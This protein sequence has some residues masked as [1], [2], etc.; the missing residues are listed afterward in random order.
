M[1]MRFLKQVKRIGRGR[2]FLLVF[3]VPAVLW[4]LVFRYFPIAYLADMSLHTGSVG[5]SKYVGLDNYRAALSDPIFRTAVLHTIEY[6]VVLV[7]LQ[8]SLA[9]LIA[10]GINSLRR[11]WARDTALT[12]YFLPL[13][14]STAAMSLVFV[15]LYDP[16]FGV[17]NYG[18]TAIGLPAQGYLHSPP[19]ALY[20]VVAMSLWKGL[21]FP[22]II[23]LAALLAI[24]RELI[25]ATAVDGASAWHRFWKLTLPLLRPTTTLLVVI[26]GVESLQVFTPV[27]VMTGSSGTPPG[28]PDNSTTVW[29]IQIYQDAFELNRLGYGAALAILMFIVVGVVMV[30]QIRKFRSGWKY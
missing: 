24:P 13:V 17:L 20:A 15:Y 7:V 5:M 23:Y 30:F 12:L 2:G 4:I 11:K 26:Q 28:G 1:I 10:I 3:L 18:L 27:F 9:L 14:A 8:L 19:Q 29:S 6:T 25:E 16:I 22:V 21:G